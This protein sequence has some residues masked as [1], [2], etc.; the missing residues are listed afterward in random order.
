MRLNGALVSLLHFAVR[1]LEG[2]VLAPT[3]SPLPPPTLDGSLVSVLVKPS[4]LVTSPK[5]IGDV[6]ILLPLAGNTIPTYE[7]SVFDSG[8]Y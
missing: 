4:T 2:E 7:D 1:L 8:Q 3:F 5:P 6:I